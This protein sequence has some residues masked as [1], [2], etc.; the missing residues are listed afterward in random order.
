MARW[1]VHQRFNSTEFWSQRTIC[2]LCLVNISSLSRG[3]HKRL[4]AQTWPSCQLYNKTKYIEVNPGNSPNVG[5]PPLHA[6]ERACWSL[7]VSFFSRE[8]YSLPTSSPLIW[9]EGIVE[10]EVY[11]EAPP[12][13]EQEF[14]TLSLSLSSI[15]PPPLEGYF[16][17]WGGCVQ[18]WVVFL[19]CRLSISI[20]ISIYFVFSFCLSISRL[21]LHCGLRLSTL[22]QTSGTL[23]CCLLPLLSSH[24][25]ACRSSKRHCRQRKIVIELILH[26]ISL[27]PD[28]VFLERAFLSWSVCHK[29][30]FSLWDTLGHVTTLGDNSRHFTTLRDTLRHFATISGL[31]SERYKL[32]IKRHKVS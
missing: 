31:C 25:S 28:K 2:P 5:P 15:H 26:V 21:L 4:N 10:G 14:Y 9:P 27:R 17:G 32:V 16:H 8:D 19:S 29:V 13:L 30:S 18:N 22:A 6:L 12:P 1:P 24:Q 7:S 23:A 3:R 20:S 11:L